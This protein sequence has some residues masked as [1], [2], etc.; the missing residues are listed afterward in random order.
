LELLS[1]TPPIYVDVAH[2]PDGAAAVAEALPEIAEG[3]PAIACMAMLDDKDATAMVRALAPVLERVVCTEL[4][5]VALSKR[6]LRKAGSRPAHEL[7]AVCEAA[8]LP[9]EE[10]PDFAVAVR[11]ARELAAGE[12]GL[13]LITGSHYVLAP[14]RIALGLCED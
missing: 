10:E 11:R 8:E 7:A 1:E 14:A 5:G 12:R 4:P 2:N 6:G 13:L 9:A 3:R